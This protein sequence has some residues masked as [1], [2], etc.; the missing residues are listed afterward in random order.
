MNPH[1]A[2]WEEMRRLLREARGLLDSDNGTRA[3]TPVPVGPL[4]GTL[5]EFDGFL[6]HN[7]LELAWDALAEVA[8]KRAAPHACWRNLSRAAALMGLPE[9]ERR[10]SQ[11]VN[12]G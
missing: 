3:G 7:E 2:S 4:A 6:G 11:R 1:A 10:A 5:D 8:E 12:E 9:K